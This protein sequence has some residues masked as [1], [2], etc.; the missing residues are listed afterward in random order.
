MGL[1]TFVKINGDEAKAYTDGAK[2][3]KTTLTLKGKLRADI[4]TVRVIGREEATSAESARDSFIVQ[5]L[6][7]DSAALDRSPFVRLLWFPRRTVPQGVQAPQHDF[8]KLNPSQ[9]RVANA[10][11]SGGNLIDRVQGASFVQQRPPTDAT[12]RRPA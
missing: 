1:Q 5:L 9:N 12:Y 2:G 7:A 10:M 11:I 3:K 4:Q 8:E 6:Q